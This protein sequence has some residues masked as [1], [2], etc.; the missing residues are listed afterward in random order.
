LK[1]VPERERESESE[2]ERERAETREEVLK[3]NNNHVVTK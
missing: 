3:E 2:R 1:L